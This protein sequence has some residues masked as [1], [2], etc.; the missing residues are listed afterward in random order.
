[1]THTQ[2]YNLTQWDPADRILREDFNADNA[3]IDTA[4]GDHNAAIKA[5]EAQKG[6]CIL[7]TTSYGGNGRYGQSNAVKLTFPRK[8]YLVIVSGGDVHL[9]LVQGISTCHVTSSTTY[10]LS[11]TWSGNSV[12]WWDGEAYGMMNSNNKTY[13][14]AALLKADG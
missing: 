7:Y 13:F 10:L 6:N 14:V 4:L 8:P 11:V 12:S 1:M 9:V 3:A 2:N 5:L